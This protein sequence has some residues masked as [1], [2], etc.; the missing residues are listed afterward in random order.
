MRYRIV[1]PL[2]ALFL[3]AACAS[4]GGSPTGGA[5]AKARRSRSVLTAEEIQQT[6]GLRTAYEAVQ[7]LR[8]YFLQ[9]RGTSGM[10]G[11]TGV[12]VYVNGMPMGGVSALNG[13]DVKDVK[14][15]RYYTASDA[16]TKY[17]S[18][19]TGGVIEVTTG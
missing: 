6:T 9:T 16:T 14:E 10:R 3:A 11:S 12:S 15:I 1:T 18:G 17:G 8:P 5:S 7:R 4:A 13:I 2:L 19:V